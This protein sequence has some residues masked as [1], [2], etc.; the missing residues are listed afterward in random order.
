ML[1]NNNKEILSSIQKWNSFKNRF[2]DNRARTEKID[3]KI[4]KKSIFPYQSPLQYKK[5][6][7]LSIKNY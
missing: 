3:L 7:N 5:K 6:E 1:V 4:N 2:E